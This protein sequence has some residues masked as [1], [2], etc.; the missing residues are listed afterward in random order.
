MNNIYRKFG[1]LAYK[2]FYLLLY[3]MFRHRKTVVKLASYGITDVRI[4]C[5]RRWYTCHGAE[6]TDRLFFKGVFNG[7]KC[8]IKLAANDSTIKK[9]IFINNYMTECGIN[10]VP[11]LLLSDSNYNINSALLVTELIQDIKKFKLPDNERAFE[12]M[13]NKFEH[14]HSCL[15]KFSIVH[16]DISLS[17]VLVDKNACIILI[18]FGIGWVPGSEIF[19]TNHL[20]HH[21]TYYIESDNVRIYDNAFSFLRVL[22]H[23]KIP[24][25]YKQKECYKKIERLV[26]VHSHIIPLPTGKKE[27][28]SN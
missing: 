17:N 14:I 13:C 11:K 16:G 25:E 5:V 23:S 3:F 4:Y 8:F 20:I 22:D 28:V 9:E 1:R 26:G 21:G 10:F 12:V 19:R 24:A 2:L 6:K 18:D 27:F 7:T 15:K